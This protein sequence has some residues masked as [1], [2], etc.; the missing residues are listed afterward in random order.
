MDHMLVRRVSGFRVAAIVFLVVAMITLVKSIFAPAYTSDIINQLNLLLNLI[1]MISFASVFQYLNEK[2]YEKLVVFGMALAF[3][4]YLSTNIMGNYDTYIQGYSEIGIGKSLDYQFLGPLFFIVAH[5]LF[6]RTSIIY[7]AII[8]Y[9][10]ALA[11]DVYL[12]LS[13]D[14]VYFSSYWPDIVSDGNAINVAFFGLWVNIYI[15]ICIMCWAIVYLSDRLLDDAVKFEKSTTNLSR[16]FSPTIREKIKEQDIQIDNSSNSSQ[17]VAVLFT[18]IDGFTSLSET[19]EP[20]QIIELLSEY[21]DKMVKPI[22]KN[23]GTVDKFI[24]DAVMATFGT[25]VSQGNDAQNAFS[26]AREMQIAM[27]QWAKE[28]SEKGLPVITHRI[29]IHYGECIVG[30]IGTEDRKE[31][32]VVGDIVNVASRICDA[33]KDL[34]ASLIFSEE[35]RI[36][37]LENVNTRLE[38]G[39]SLK[40]KE[41][42]FNLHCI[43]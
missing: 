34:K 33:G 17:P 43:D 31:Y 35:V 32:T 18:D 20:N 26:C 4:Y 25:P 24:G 38:T 27:S 29:G 1:T 39:V 30:N 6:L 36:R 10:A 13:S 21:Q 3:A 23:L 15:T 37:L 22:F 28:R 9:S 7:Y 11:R 12:I 42:G 8:V 5:S 40:G 2:N 19:L 41:K 14:M 16:Y